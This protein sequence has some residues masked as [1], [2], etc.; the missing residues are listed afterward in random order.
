MHTTMHTI[1]IAGSG[2]R[3]ACAPGQDLLRAMESLGRRG[4]PAGCRGG[5][6][7][8]C[9]VHV[10]AGRFHTGKMSRACVSDAEQGEGFVLAC[11]AYPDSNLRL[12]P[13]A[14]LR[15]CLERQQ[16]R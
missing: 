14:Q 7:G 9:K 10:E 3:Y 1:E 13:V 16:T 2:E 11:K 5:G 12:R 15:R 8:V 6:C 4:I